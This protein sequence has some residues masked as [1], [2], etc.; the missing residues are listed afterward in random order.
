VI[1]FLD[2]LDDLLLVR[3][4]G[5]F[6]QQLG[7][8]SGEARGIRRIRVSGWHADGRTCGKPTSG[9]KVSEAKT[10]TLSGAKLR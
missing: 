10:E 1:H 5:A 8:V 7:L 3:L 6:A 2:S 4:H 9:S